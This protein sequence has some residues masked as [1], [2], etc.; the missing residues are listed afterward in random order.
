MKKWKEAFVFINSHQGVEISY[1]FVEIIPDENNPF[2]KAE[3]LRDTFG[4][5]IVSKHTS[6]ELTHYFFDQY[7]EQLSGLS[8]EFDAVFAPNLDF[9]TRFWKH[10]IY[11][12]ETE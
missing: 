9:L 10:D 11:F 8:S 1:N 3:K 4:D 5:V 7:K 12:S 2:Y 6:K